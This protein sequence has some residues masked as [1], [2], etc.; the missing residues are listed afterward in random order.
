MQALEL[1]IPPPVIMLV[2]ATAMWLLGRW[3]PQFSLPSTALAIVGATL[4]LTGVAITV[5]GMLS[6]R[7]H[8][9]T[10]NP[11]KPQETAMLVTEGVYGWTRNPMYLG[12]AV[13]LA[14][15]ACYLANGIALLVMPA[16]IA[17]ITWFQ[18]I[19]EE[20]ALQRKF[21]APFVKYLTQVRRWL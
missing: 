9:T 10:I 20:R 12:L 7:R 5:F 3:L 18:I 8:K 1:K 21:G 13:L 16:F 6:F 4:A 11:L 2:S 14:G 15:W 17:Y 19:P